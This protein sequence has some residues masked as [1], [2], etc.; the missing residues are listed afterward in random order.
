MAS[1]VDDRRHDGIAPVAYLSAA[2][3]RSRQRVAR[4]CIDLSATIDGGR[5]YVGRNAA[6]VDHA[7]TAHRKCQILLGYAGVRSD[8]AAARHGKGPCNP[9]ALD[10]DAEPILMRTTVV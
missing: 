7:A 6:C 1:A 8:R 3:H 10:E 2:V 5:H 4:A 9:W